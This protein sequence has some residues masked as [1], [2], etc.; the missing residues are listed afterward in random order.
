MNRKQRKQWILEHQDVF[1]ELGKQMALDTYEHLKGVY[2]EYTGKEYNKDEAFKNDITTVEKAYKEQSSIFQDINFYLNDSEL[3]DSKES[4]CKEEINGI[5]LS[6][7]LKE[8]RHDHYK[9]H[10]IYLFIKNKNVL[11]KI[12][13]NDGNATH[14]KIS[15]KTR[16]RI[17]KKAQKLNA[18]IYHVHNHPSS[19][20]AYP[21]DTDEETRKIMSEDLESE[22][23]KLLDWAVVTEWDYYSYKQKGFVPNL[24]V[25]L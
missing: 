24:K 5:N 25:Q 2:K 21:S 11:D 22:G 3:I 8:I 14:V 20:V 19:F 1:L 7:V 13:I 10:S 16:N 17:I 9:E 6:E 4:A 12:T 18:D 23:I 15:S